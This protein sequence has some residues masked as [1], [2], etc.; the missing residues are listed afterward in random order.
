MS[1]LNQGIHQAERD[2]S[3]VE[4]L[5]WP[6]SAVLITTDPSICT[7]PLL[8]K[9]Q[10]YHSCN[11]A[12][13]ART[14]TM[15]PLRVKTGRKNQKIEDWRSLAVVIKQREREGKKS[16]VYRWGEKISR[17]EFNR[18]KNDTWLS[19]VD[20]QNFQHRKKELNPI[21]EI[22]IWYI[23][24]SS[25]TIFRSGSASSLRY[26]QRCCVRFR[27]PFLFPSLTG[28]CWMISESN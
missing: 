18:C 24:K 28:K 4:Y 5:I 7:L 10:P 22:M 8:D 17:R 12:P 19:S 23:K 25:K 9:T 6:R 16:E 26:L 20:G 1:G 13:E 2:P 21:L 14:L 3:R 27:S 15:P 11:R